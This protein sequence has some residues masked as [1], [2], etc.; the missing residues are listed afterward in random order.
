[1]PGKPSTNPVTNLVHIGR[2]MA[3]A[4]L[5]WQMA[6]PAPSMAADLPV[7]LELVLAVDV[8]GSMDVQ[9]QALQRRGYAE[10]FL[11]PE[12]LTALRAGP[13]GRIAVTYVE[14]AGPGAQSVA[15]PWTLVED[16][17]TAGR[18]A[19]AIATAPTPRLR[20]TSISGALAFAAPLFQA[21]GYAGLRR[22]IDV[23]GDGANNAG[24]P[25]VPVRDAVVAAGIVING[26]PLTVSPSLERAVGGPDLT[27]YYRDC[28]IGGPG[29]FVIA[30]NEPG[31][32]LEPIRR[33]LILEIAGLPARVEPAAV[34]AAQDR[35][36]CLIG[37]RLRR[38]WERDP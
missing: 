14:W 24:A 31:Q 4:V 5:V 26:L 11:H 20:G 1:V 10:A 25:L 30:A 37:E 35:V 29:S 16:A 38:N 2:A 34:T 12:V 13:Y 17:A 36:D 23:S 7:D 3:G 32:F 6:L 33:K 19:S 27:A 21:S 28:V 15:V 22:A 8:S 18:L 9:E